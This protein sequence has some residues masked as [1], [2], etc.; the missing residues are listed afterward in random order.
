MKT[1]GIT[2]IIGSGK[3]TIC[4]VFEHLGIPV[5]YSDEEAKKAYNNP[6]VLQKVLR[7]FGTMVTDEAGH[8]DKAQIAAMVFSDKKKLQQ[9]NDIIH[10]FVAEDFKR[11]KKKQDSPYILFESAIVFECGFEHWFDDMIVVSTP[12]SESVER[13]KC[14]SGISE[15]EIKRRLDNQQIIRNNIP[16]VRFIIDNAENSMVL[17]QILTIHEMIINN[18]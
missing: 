2:G 5:Y 8:L 6:L 17:P 15:V 18:D 12:E 13:V 9:L 7:T 16:K 4:H 10:P 11:W 14:R 1:I 3:T